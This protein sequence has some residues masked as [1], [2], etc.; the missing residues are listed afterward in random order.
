[1]T[2]FTF[3]F[4]KYVQTNINKHFYILNYLMPVYPQSE[5]YRASSI[6]LSIL[7]VFP[8]MINAINK[9]YCAVCWK[10][11]LSNDQYYECLW[12]LWTNLKNNTT[13][14][15][16]IFRLRLCKEHYY[17]KDFQLRGKFISQSSMWIFV[18]CWVF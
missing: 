16:V 5:C 7:R 10:I 17:L 9:M 6:N 4:V 15:S 18:F 2:I 8:N 12:I 13:V 1:M 11:C 3:V 14:D